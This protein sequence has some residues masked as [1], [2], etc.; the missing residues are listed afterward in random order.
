MTMELPACRD[1]YLLARRVTDEVRR[2]GKHF[3]PLPVLRRLDAL[4]SGHATDR[5]PY[6]RTFLDCVLDKHDGRYANRTYLALPLLDMVLD[7]PEGPL[8]PNHMATLLIADVVRFESRVREP[9]GPD[10]GPAGGGADPDPP[11]PDTTRKRLRH[12]LRFVSDDLG[13]L[14]AGDV[15]DLLPRPPA[16]AAGRWFDLTV[17]PV[18]VLHDEFFFIRALQAHEMLFTA[19]VA[20]VRAAITALRDG[21][22]GAAARHVDRA[23]ASVDRAAALFRLVATMRPDHFTGFRRYTQG[24]SAIQS[25][26]YKRFEVLCGLPSG[27]RLCSAA[28]AGVPAVRAEAEDAAHDTVARAYLDLRRRTPVGHAERELLHAALA[29]LEDRHQRWKATHRS[30][31]A[32]ML[33]D[34]PGSGYTDG[35]PYLTACLGNRLFRQ[36]AERPAARRVT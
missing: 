20:E 11:G 9:R 16:T 33:G 27:E 30:L 10:T 21:R 28:F 4:R 29:R 34:A 23:A 32:R 31:A 15:A 22:P 7:D 12:A 18:Y 1:G 19:V 24:A 3:L 36:L 17:Q 26:Q 6:L 35:V 25:E 5:L 13:G 8:D 14:D 2:T